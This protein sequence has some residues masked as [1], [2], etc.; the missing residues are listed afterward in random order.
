MPSLASITEIENRYTNG[1]PSLGSAYA[2]LRERWAD[3]PRD[4]ETALRLLFLAWYSNAEP[5]FLTGLPDGDH[6]AVVSETFNA[7]G[8][9]A[10]TDA[11][12]CFVV[13]LMAS[14]FPCCLG[15]ETE[16]SNLGHVLWRRAE[17]LAP[18][19]LTAADF[20][21]RGAYGEYFAHMLRNHVWKA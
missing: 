21:G 6:F 19:T 1:E 8:G 12:V 7:L 20:E 18:G 15:D 3:G 13:G 11:E 17:A 14:L 10:S 16:W 9:A 4:R 5:P 2:L